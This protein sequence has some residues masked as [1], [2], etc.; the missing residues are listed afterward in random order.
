MSVHNIIFNHMKSMVSELMEIVAVHM[1]T[2]SLRELQQHDSLLFLQ[3][4]FFLNPFINAT[5]RI[6]S[7]YDDKLVTVYCKT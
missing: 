4:N 2:D 5:K 3:E 1:V 7:S 6:Y